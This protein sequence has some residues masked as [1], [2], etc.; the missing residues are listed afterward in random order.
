ML[1]GSGAVTLFGR[2]SKLS[3]G[4][5]D[6]LLRAKGSGAIKDLTQATTL[7]VVGDGATNLIARGTL[8][9]RL[10][11]ADR[12]GIQ[13]AGEMRLLDWLEGRDDPPGTLATGRASPQ[14][15][16]LLAAFDLIRVT[17]GKMRFQDAATLKSA[18]DLEA[19][20]MAQTD[21]LQTLRTKRDAPRGRH[22]LALSP[23][24]APYLAWDDGATDLS[25]QGILDLEDLEGLEILF[26]EALE[27]EAMGDLASAARGFDQCRRADKKDPIAPFNLGNVRVAQG[28]PEGARLAF[29]IALARDPHFAEAHFNL[30]ALLEQSGQIEQAKT[31]LSAAIQHAP[32]YA[33]PH[34]NL[35][36]LHLKADARAAA[37]SHFQ[38][39]MSLAP[40]HPLSKTA[41]R[42]LT[43]LRGMHP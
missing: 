6:R 32:A 37:L 12:R 35:A 24:G 4:D 25:G 23:A 20:D 3:R 8:D 38:Q 2:F 13:I 18:E 15:V 31:H 26:E 29:E 7:F 1:E 34:F 9:R 36:Q 40:N 27:A 22:R 14:L 33:D 28:D 11:E 10:A 16:R 19:A 42:A 30:A 41:E 17:A 43:L 21:I 39:F 5:L